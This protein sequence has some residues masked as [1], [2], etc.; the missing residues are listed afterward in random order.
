MEFRKEE[1]NSQVES[2]DNHLLTKNTMI[3]NIPQFGNEERGLKQLFFLLNGLTLAKHL[4]SL[5]LFFY[6]FKRHIKRAAKVQG[7][8]QLSLRQ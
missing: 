4:I 1:L 6:I 7:L 8:F 2:N 5:V 3:T